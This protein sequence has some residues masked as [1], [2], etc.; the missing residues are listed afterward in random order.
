MLRSL[1]LKIWAILI[2]LLLVQCSN[3]STGPSDGNNPG[4]N[5]QGERFSGITLTDKD[6][7]VLGGDTTDWCYA[8]AKTVNAGEN[9]P[10]PESYALYPAYVN[11][12]GGPIHIDYDLPASSNVHLYIIDTSETVIR[13]LVNES[14]AAGHYSAIWDQED[15]AGDFVSEGIY[16]CLLEA[17][18]FSCFGDIQVDSTPDHIILYSQTS[19]NNLVIT[20]EATEPAGAVFMEFDTDAAMGY[21]I[22]G[23][24]AADMSFG[25]GVVNGKYRLLVFSIDDPPSFI[26]GGEHTLC[27]IPIGGP[28]VI[29]SAQASDTLGQILKHGILNL[30]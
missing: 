25:P 21:P 17:G 3:D 18:D 2:V 27:T 9:L 15:N 4:N 20:Y 16:G 30:P 19:G 1:I 6:G 13:D 24:G 5:G 14:Q 26:L 12:S 22:P 29:D 11:P 23:D 28:M 8:T 10:L 7:L